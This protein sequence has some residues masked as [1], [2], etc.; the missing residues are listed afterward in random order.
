MINDIKKLNI[1]K[2][3]NLHMMKSKKF[4]TDLI[5]VYIKRPLREEEATKNA[6]LSRLLDRATAS[7]P[8][9]KDFA[10]KLE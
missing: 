3:V 4:K 7:Y 9:S 6:L 2:N 10:I 1:S 5:G 8:T